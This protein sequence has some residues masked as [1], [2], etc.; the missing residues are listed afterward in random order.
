MRELRSTTAWQPKE[1]CLNSIQIVEEFFGGTHL[2]SSAFELPGRIPLLHM[3]QLAEELERAGR[4]VEER[5]VD[6][7]GDVPPYATDTVI[8][9]GGRT[10]PSA[11]IAELKY[12]V[13]LCD[14]SYVPDLLLDWGARL[15]LDDVIGFRD[16][17]AAAVTGR[18]GLE[19]AISHVRPLAAAIR[20]GILEPVPTASSHHL[21]DRVVA[22]DIRAGTFEFLRE[23]P[24]TRAILQGQLGVTDFQLK[25]S[26]TNDELLASFDIDLGV[27]PELAA[28]VVSQY[29]AYSLVELGDAIHFYLFCSELNARPI[30]TNSRIER[31]FEMATAALLSVGPDGQPSR[32]ALSDPANESARNS[33][34]EALDAAPLELSRGFVMPMPELSRVSVGDLVELRQQDEVWMM[35][36]DALTTLSSTVRAMDSSEMRYLDYL[37]EF[38]T[39]AS[40]ELKDPTKEL[41][42]VLTKERWKSRIVTWTGAGLVR[43]T[44]RGAAL[45]FPPFGLA[46]GPAGAGTGKLI[47]RKAAPKIGA[48]TTANTL[49]LSLT[50]E[51]SVTPRF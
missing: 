50:E 33:A 48:L 43:L 42:S 5:P 24:V 12:Q 20:L 11:T 6:P 49:M 46:A 23:D 36:R 29:G 17:E 16:P 10:T 1:N 37:A 38:R 19:A 3:V 34:A 14:R 27:T 35:V 15:S 18:A 30:T 2:E 26:Y 4:A 44:V 21:R 32:G 13:L 9:N 41:Q 22:R 40:R 39:V 51:S 25:N 28:R 45:M 8:L 47:E 31:H 7:L